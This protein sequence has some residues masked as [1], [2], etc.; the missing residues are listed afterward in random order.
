MEYSMDDIKTELGKKYN[1]KRKYILE[2]HRGAANKFAQGWVP[3]GS[4]PDSTDNDTG[5]MV[6][7]ESPK[8]GV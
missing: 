4:V 3:V 1:P 7:M 8:E 6:I 2:T 5:T